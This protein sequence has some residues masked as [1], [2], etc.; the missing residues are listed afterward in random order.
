MPDL[1]CNGAAMV[2]KQFTM[3]VFVMPAGEHR[4]DWYNSNG[5]L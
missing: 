5:A 3:P 4:S 1:E 2:L